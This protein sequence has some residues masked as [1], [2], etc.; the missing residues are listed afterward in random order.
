M[1]YLTWIVKVAENFFTIVR[2]EAD[3]VAIQPQGLKNRQKAK[4]FHLMEI[5]NYVMRKVKGFKKKKSLY[6]T[7][8]NERIVSQD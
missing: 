1:A 6:P 7:C 3:R 4:S 8:R 2:A 5:G